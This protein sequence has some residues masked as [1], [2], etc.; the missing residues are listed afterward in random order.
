MRALSEFEI[1]VGQPVNVRV[2]DR[3]GKLLLECGHKVSSETARQALLS[4]GFV[5]DD[6]ATAAGGRSSEAPVRDATPTA[7]RTHRAP[8]TW[9]Q[10]P[11]AGIA[12]VREELQHVVGALS[13]P[14]EVL[15]AELGK[16]VSELGQ[17]LVEYV[18]QDPDCALAVTQ[19]SSREEGAASRPVHA[20]ILTELIGQS[21]GIDDSER[22]SL[23][24]AA[25]TFDCTL[26]RLAEVFNDQRAELTEE[27]RRV[28]HDHPLCAVQVLHSLGIED[29]V[30]LNAVEQ[31]HERLDGS[32][33]PH[34]LKGDA[35]S[36][37]ARIVA[38]SDI[39]CALIRPR[40]YRGA[41]S[42]TEAMRSIFLERGRLVDES[43]A[44]MLIRGIGVYPPGALVRLE[45]GEIALVFR[46][47]ETPGRPIVRCLLDR[48]GRPMADRPERST[49]LPGYAIE[50]ALSAERYQ[51]LLVGQTKLWE[52]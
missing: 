4:R 29:P 30:W 31:H 16:R 49:Q 7:L 51:A 19:L 40:A 44:A 46:R 52:S 1:R 48:M 22:A 47:S 13:R 21:L 12:R 39:Y 27:Q 50:E 8:T 5:R 9:P 15:G 43:I 20:A 32:G 41:V 35:I 11:A 6:A 10:K 26:A 24:C 36:R 23:V 28:I 33:Y 45:N 18:Q 42:A 3:E 37:G 14:D 25:L 17:R 38:L 34:G 2:Y